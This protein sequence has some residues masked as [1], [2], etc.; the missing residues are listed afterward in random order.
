MYINNPKVYCKPKSVVRSYRLEERLIN[1]IASKV[2]EHVYWSNNAIV[3]CVLG[4]FLKF[5]SSKQVYAILHWS[6]DNPL[7][8]RVKLEFEAPDGQWYDIED[9]TRFNPRLFKVIQNPKE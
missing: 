3:A 9:W 7:N 1:M 8:L 4:F 6:L 2:N 5:L